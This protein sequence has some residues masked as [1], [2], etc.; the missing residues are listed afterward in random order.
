MFEQ[1]ANPWW[2][3]VLLGIC[4]GI[5]SGLLGIGGGV[6]MVPALVLIMGFAQK[7]AQGM[8]LAVMVPM[9]LVGAMRYWRN[10][11]VDMDFL[12]VGLIVCGSLT[13]VIIGTELASHLPAG[14]LRKLFAVIF[15]IIA[16]RMFF[17]PSNQNGVDGD[18]TGQRKDTISKIEFGSTE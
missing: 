7:S 6:L 15:I 16:I 11:D 5:L 10:G 14:M 4:A 8:S 17:G 3:F 18:N 13:G 1:L 2:A 12:V 9:A